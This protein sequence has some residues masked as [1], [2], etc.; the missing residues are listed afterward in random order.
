MV[1]IIFLEAI[2][3]FDLTQF[4][5]EPMGDSKP[6][7]GAH[8]PTQ[9]LYQQSIVKNRPDYWRDWASEICRYSTYWSAY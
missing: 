1:G 4:G 3:K 9:F 2:F 6:V 7:S 8:A 5:I